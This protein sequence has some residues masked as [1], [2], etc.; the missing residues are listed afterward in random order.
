MKA[1]A[2][3]HC[4]GPNRA[5]SPRNLP[6]L[7]ASFVFNDELITPETAIAAVV[8]RRHGIPAREQDWK[9]LQAYEVKQSGGRHATSYNRVYV[10]R[11]EP[12][13]ALRMELGASDDKIDPFALHQSCYLQPIERK[14]EQTS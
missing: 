7:I 1:I 10:L 3:T 12:E 9:I 5:L 2:Y 4:A 8:E 6:I 13:K 11:Y 14:S